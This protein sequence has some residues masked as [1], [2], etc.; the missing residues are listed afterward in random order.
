MTMVM[1]MAMVTD[2][3]CLGDDDGYDGS[4]PGDACVRGVPLSVRR[5]CATR[6]GLVTSSLGGGATWRGM[7]QGND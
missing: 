2:G 3:G 1:I 6:S 5:Q 7:R 4:P